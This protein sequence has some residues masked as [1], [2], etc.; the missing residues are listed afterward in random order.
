MA[1]K[2]AAASAAYKHMQKTS[3]EKTRF[4]LA[5]RQQPSSFSCINQEEFL[6]KACHIGHKEQLGPK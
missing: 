2:Y 5:G 1:V 4:M 3:Y 6:P